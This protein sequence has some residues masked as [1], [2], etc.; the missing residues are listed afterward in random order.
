MLLAGKD[1]SL[2]KDSV[3]EAFIGIP[4]V[5][6]GRAWRSPDIDG[7]WKPLKEVTFCQL[8]SEYG[9]RSDVG[10]GT[11]YSEADND[12]IEPLRSSMPL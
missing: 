3:V 12:T 1:Q 5:P 11:E 6:S 4:T 2:Q 8:A 10:V 7:V 9:L